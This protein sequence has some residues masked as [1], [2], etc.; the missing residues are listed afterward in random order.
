MEPLRKK[1][2]EL[3]ISVVKALRQGA[4]VV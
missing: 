3:R 2:V 1:K 4:L